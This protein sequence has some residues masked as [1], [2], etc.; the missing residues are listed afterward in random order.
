MGYSLPY[1]TDFFR[2]KGKILSKGFIFNFKFLY[3]NGGFEKDLCLSGSK[4]QIE[5]KNVAT[6][7]LPK[8]LTREGSLKLL[9]QP[10]KKAPTGLCNRCLMQLMYRAGLRVSEVINLGPRDIEWKQGILRVGKEKGTKD[11]TL[12]LDEHTL[13]LLRVWNERRTKGR[14]FF[15]TF[16]CY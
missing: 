2:F 13:D 5:G 14:Y 9:S 8:T 3:K 15:C 6:K 7:K 16:D 11:R 10:N 1:L 12:Y 4:A